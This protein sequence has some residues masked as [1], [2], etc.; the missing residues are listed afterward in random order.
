[1]PTE[2]DAK[3]ARVSGI[4]DLD[5]LSSRVS[6]RKVLLFGIGDL[7]RKKK[8]WITLLHRL[9]VE[10]YLADFDKKAS[11]LDHI[12]TL[13]K[14]F[15]QIENP[16]HEEKLRQIAGKDCFDLIDISTWADSHLSLALRFQ[17]AARI[18]VDTKPVDTHLDLLRTIHRNSASP[19]PYLYRHLLQRFLVHDHYGG[20]WAV[21]EAAR[22]MAEWQARHGFI[23]EIQVYV[24]ESKSVNREA[25]R[26]GALKDGICFDLAPHVFCMLQALMPIGATWDCDGLTYSRR[27]IGLSV[28]GGARDQNVG[29]PITGSK[30]NGPVETFA[31]ISLSGQDVIYINGEFG[32]EE[33]KPFRCLVVV[34]KG[35]SSVRGESR[36]TKGISIRFQTGDYL[37]IDLESQRI[38]T[39]N[40]DIILPPEDILHRGI[41][42]PLIELTKAEFPSVLPDDIAHFFQPLEGAYVAAELIDAS[43]RLPWLGKAYYE[44]EECVS[45]VNLIPTEYWRNLPWHLQIMP[46]IRLGDVPSTTEQIY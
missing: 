11:A 26:V 6:G 31:A 19:K 45:R 34:G 17:D 32:R 15:F 18:I 12:G 39:P 1:M 27:E 10:I 41:N 33:S 40:G 30:D 14:D 22:H 20:R 28:V 38:R 5:A 29:C 43:R 13:A 8:P 23:E 36:D 35:I 3:L 24:L 9:G 44:G 21:Q 42:L 2:D 37:Q 46:Q 4:K 25:K 7:A 16:S